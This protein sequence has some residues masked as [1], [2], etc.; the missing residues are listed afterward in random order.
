MAISG[1]VIITLHQPEKKECTK[2]ETLRNV[3]LNFTPLRLNVILGIWRV[4]LQ[5][6][7]FCFCDVSNV[8]PFQCNLYKPSLVMNV[9]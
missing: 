7:V 2:Y 1:S 5:F 9:I 4:L 6:I 8:L 3:M